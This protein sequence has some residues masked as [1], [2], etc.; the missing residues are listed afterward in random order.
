MKKPAKKNQVRIHKT[1]LLTI[2]AEIFKDLVDGNLSIHD[3]IEVAFD[4]QQE[5]AILYDIQGEIV[6]N[7]LY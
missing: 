1:L 4:S 2:A 6:A 3:F 5:Q 7:Y